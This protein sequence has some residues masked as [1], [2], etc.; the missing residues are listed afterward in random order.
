MSASIMRIA[1]AAAAT[2]LAGVAVFHIVLALGAPLGR[3]AWGGNHTRLPVALRLGS[4]ASA[5]VLCAAALIVLGRAGLWTADGPAGLYRW[6]VWALA[7]LLGLSSVGNFASAGRW[8]NLLMGPLALTLALLC[9]LVAL[10]PAHPP[11]GPPG[12][13]GPGA[14]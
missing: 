4:V 9:L 12:A 2:G 13:A 1:A 7:L 14:P 8:E 6:G 11:G 5:V 3:A 10:G